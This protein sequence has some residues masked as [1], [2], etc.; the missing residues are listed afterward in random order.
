MSSVH[1]VALRTGIEIEYEDHGVGERPFVLVHGFTGSRDDWRERL[2]ELARLGRTIALDQ[3]GHGGS[4]KTGDAASYT[5]ER[6]VDDLAALHDALGLGPW[7]LLG[8]SLGGMVVLRLALAH[9]RCVRSLILMNTA[10]HGVP[11]ATRPLLEAG[12]Q[13]GRAQ[14]MAALAAVMRAGQSRAGPP[15]PARARVVAEMGEDAFWA[16]AAR[17]IAQ[18]EPESFLALGTAL[19]EQEAVTGRLGEL[20]V[21]TTLL[22][23]DQDA[24]FLEA[25]ETMRTGITDATSVILKDA[26]HSPQLETPGPWLDAVRAHLDRVR[27]LRSS[28]S[29]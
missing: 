16:R 1:R 25:T 29:G 15:A 20:G 23:G 19:H 18:M 7:D 22:V 28:T 3:R 10:P 21:P 14:G 9:P 2:P 24:P 17:K 5:F 8:H 13:L 11:L 27:A 12:A 4:T 26:A 6:L